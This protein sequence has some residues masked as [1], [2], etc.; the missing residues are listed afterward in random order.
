MSL[1]AEFTSAG[2]TYRAFYNDADERSGYFDESGNSME[3]MLLKSPLKY[4][5][6]ITSR[7]G[8][9]RHPVLGYTRMHRG[10]DYGVPTGTPIWSVGDAKVLRAGVNGG[11]GKFIELKHANGWVSRYAHLSRID[12]KRGQKV[13]Q[14]DIIGAVG[15][16]GMSTGPHLHYELLRNGSHVNPQAQK[17]KRGKP[18]TGTALERYLDAVSRVSD[19]LNST[20]VAT[21]RS[22]DS[23]K[24]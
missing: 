23:E 14:K 6:N 21:S 16:T 15:S 20:G 1:G 11:Y 18:L 2:E 7:Y 10:V 8:K 22:T 19:R 5:A 13:K 4:A 24:G 3:K 17:F 12:V 9:R